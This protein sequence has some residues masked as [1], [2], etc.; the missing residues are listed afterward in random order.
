MT[1]NS[2]ETTQEVL[3]LMDQG[4]ELY[5]EKE[6]DKKALECFLKVHELDPNYELA[7]VALGN[8]YMWMEDYDNALIYLK[9]L[10]A[11]DETD[12]VSNIKMAEC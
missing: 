9:K 10:L 7:V 6:E 2:Q 11:F 8:V 4:T 5:E 1:E 12:I 3:D